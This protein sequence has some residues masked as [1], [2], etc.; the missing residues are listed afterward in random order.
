MAARNARLAK[1]IA[2]VSALVLL[3]CA[4]A[5]QTATPTDTPTDTPPSADY[6]VEVFTSPEAAG[7]V[8]S[9]IVIA[10]GKALVIDAQYTK[11][12]AAAVADKIEGAGATLA[13][14]FITHAHPDHYLG[15]ATLLE[16]FPEAR[17]VAV[18]SVVEGIAATAAGK[19]EAA[20]GQLGDEFPGTPVIPEA[21]DGDT[22]RFAGHA[23]P[24]LVGLQGDT[25]PVTGVVLADAGTAVLSDVVFS[26][27][28]AWTADSTHES[29]IAWMSE[30]DRLEGLEGV[31]RFVPGHQTAQAK[32]DSS[33][34]RYTHEYIA[35]FDASAQPGTASGDIIAAMQRSYPD[36]GGAFFLQLGAKVA[37]GE[38]VWE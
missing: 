24:L 10:G 26:G 3:G 12:G 35:A 2:C 18:P 23:F 15:A 14:V 7:A 16:R 9:T 38:L 1:P 31:E 20:A 5:G 13:A 6:T 19:A 27:V 28:H 32:Q 17:V 34:L 4:S 29:R 37:A 8:N 36:V 33:A 11:S 22:L 30:L 21:I 25:D